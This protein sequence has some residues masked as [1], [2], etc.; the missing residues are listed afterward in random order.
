MCLRINTCYKKHPFR[1]NVHKWLYSKLDNTLYSP[2]RRIVYPFGNGW[3]VARNPILDI[4]YPTRGNQVY[5]N[6]LFGGAIHSYAKVP[7][8]M[9]LDTTYYT[10]YPAIAV[11]VVARGYRNSY[12]GQEVASTFLYIPHLDKHKSGVYHPDNYTNDQLRKML[13]GGAK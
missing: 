8:W 6:K 4:R 10:T 9:A 13:M 1:M 5:D 3:F 11:N 7:K 12:D 2:Y